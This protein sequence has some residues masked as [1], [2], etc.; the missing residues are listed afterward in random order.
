VAVDDQA[1]DSVAVHLEDSEA[2][3]EE[4]SAAADLEEAG[5]LASLNTEINEENL[6]SKYY[7][8]CDFIARLVFHMVF[9]ETATFGI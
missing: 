7:C 8:H 4:V 1:A 3:A 6:E 5:N 9:R 2:L